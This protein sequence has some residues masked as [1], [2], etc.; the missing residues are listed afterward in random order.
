M[1]DGNIVWCDRELMYLKND[2]TGAESIYMVY[3][4]PA[5]D[6][7]NSCD[8]D[9]ASMFDNSGD[10]GDF[11][12]FKFYNTLDGATVRINEYCDGQCLGGLYLHDQ[13]TDDE[14]AAAYAKLISMLGG[15]T[16]QKVIVQEETKAFQMAVDEVQSLYFGETLN[17]DGTYH[18]PLGDESVVSA[19][20]DY[21]GG[22]AG[23]DESLW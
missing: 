20:R 2:Q 13:K 7:L 22:G 10:M 9:L 8:G 14:V 21:G 1:P 15:V 16:L 3:Y 11:T 17:P 5:L 19:E 18:F 23:V 12:G 4:L 6:Y